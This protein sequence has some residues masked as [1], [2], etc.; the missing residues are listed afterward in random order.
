MSRKKNNSVPRFKN[1]HF[2]SIFSMSLVLFLVGLV[3]VL[4]FTAR[5]LSIRV[6]ENINLSIIL[7]NG[8]TNTEIVRIKNYLNAAPFTKSVKYISK[9]DALKELIESLGEDPQEFLGYNPLMESF[10]VKLHANYANNDSVAKIES[11]LKTFPHIN[12]VA[13]QKDVVD[14]VNENIKKLSYILLVL[15]V[16][17]LLISLALINSTIRL[18]IYSNRF[19]INTM[20]LVGAT[21][22]FIRWPYVRRSII[23]GLIAAFL[24]LIYLAGTI[25][26]VQYEFGITKMSLPT[27]T[28]ISVSAIVLLLGIL[29]SG[30]SS[31]FAVGRYLR[32]HTN[33]MYFV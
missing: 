4:L 13:Y 28:A 33:D 16:I 21:S 18:Q 20:K 32:M 27:V 6:R 25:A 12:R 10:E 31:Y 22:W 19:L 15:A 7:D 23:N 8:V 30:I 24:A 14:L 26:Y 2:T 29:L 5:D 3:C 17:L 1:I 11:K 9:D